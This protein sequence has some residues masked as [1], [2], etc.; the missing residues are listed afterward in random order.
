MLMVVDGL[1]ALVVL[2]ALALWGWH[3]W[4]GRGLPARAVLPNLAA[5]ALLMLALH[6]ALSSAQWLQALA[7]LAAAGLCHAMDLRS[8]WR[9]RPGPRGVDR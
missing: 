8:R 3:R 7:S 5:G 4:T 6:F 9:D 2:E 1:I